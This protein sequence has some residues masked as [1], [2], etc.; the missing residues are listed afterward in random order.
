MQ[1]F[2]NST[3]ITKKNAFTQIQFIDWQTQARAY[4]KYPNF[5]RRF[6]LDDYPQLDFIKNFGKSTFTKKYGKD[7]VNLRSNPSAGGLYPCEIYIQI[8]GVKSFLN[9]IYHYEPLENNLCLIHELTNDGVEYYLNIEQHEF[10]ILIS[11]VYFRTTW[12]YEKRAIRYLLLDSGHQLA[13]IYSALLLKEFEFNFSFQIKSLN[14]LFSFDNYEHFLAAIY[15][16]P[17]KQI[18]T[19]EL[20][21]KIPFVNPCDYFIKDDFIE[22]Y[23]SNFYKENF[24]EF[25]PK[26]LNNLKKS[27][28]QEAIDKRRSARAFKNESI[29]KKEFETILKDIF[30]FSNKYGLEIFFINH[31]IEG[32]EK[33]IYKESNLQKS[34]E[35]RELSKELAFNQNIG[36]TS[37]VTLFFTSKIDS[38]YSQNYIIAGFLAHIIMLRATNLK[39]NSTGIGA[40]FDDLSKKALDTTNN[41]LYLVGL[42]K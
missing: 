21:E 26:F 19:K 6:S 32:L 38:N 11:N 24:I 2:H 14:E 42:G 22:N 9:G 17:Y 31:N 37:A 10:I 27:D 15:L 12:K 16:N 7:E 18:K 35:F 5:F 4:K 36:G 3:D 20:R 30:E 29:L 39:I 41:I 34:G 40:Y 25:K 23:Y 1:E 28:L 33:A 13:S 8:R